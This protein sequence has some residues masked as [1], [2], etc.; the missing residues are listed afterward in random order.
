MGSKTQGQENLQKNLEAQEARR[1][2]RR[3][4][5][6]RTMTME[7]F[8]ESARTI[9]VVVFVHRERTFAGHQ[10]AWESLDRSATLRTYF[11]R[12]AYDDAKQMAVGRRR[13]ELY[14]VH[15]AVAREIES[16]LAPVWTRG[17]LEQTQTST[18]S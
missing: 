8:I 7:T 16:Q 11:R 18:E 13:F 4:H 17:K 10:S 12:F 9:P 14:D 1:E 6:Q 2:A 5:K 15:E 3:K